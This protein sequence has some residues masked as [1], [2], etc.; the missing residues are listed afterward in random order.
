M[1]FFFQ[2]LHVIDEETKLQ[3]GEMCP[4]HSWL[5]EALGLK[6]KDSDFKASAF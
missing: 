1:I 6:P 2:F 5:V 4:A 3:I